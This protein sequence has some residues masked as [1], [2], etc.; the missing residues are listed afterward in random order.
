MA[1]KEGKWPLKIEVKGYKP[2]NLVAGKL[3]ENEA[4]N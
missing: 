3:L 4:L 2:K 1:V